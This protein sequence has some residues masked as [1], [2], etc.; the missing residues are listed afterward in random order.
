MFNT[1][2]ID[3]YNL[4]KQGKWFKSLYNSKILCAGLINFKKLIRTI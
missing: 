1:K 4:S 3:N 2:N